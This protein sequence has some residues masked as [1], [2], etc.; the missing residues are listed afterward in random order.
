HLFVIYGIYRL[1]KTSSLIDIIYSNPGNKKNHS[2]NFYRIKEYFEN[3]S[4]YYSSSITLEHVATHCKSTIH[5]VSRYINEVIG[6]NFNDFIN[7]KRIEEAKRRLYAP[8]YKH[9]SNEGIGQS[10]G[11]KSKT[12]FYRAFKKFTGKTPGEYMKNTPELMLQEASC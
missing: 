7:K 10:V 3:T 1:I 12:T 11:F 2:Q 9:L 8:E 6:M 4:D 5:D